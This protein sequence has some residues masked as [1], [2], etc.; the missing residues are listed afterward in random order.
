M[1]FTTT[2]VATILL[3]S[4]STAALPTPHTPHGVVSVDSL[5]DRSFLS[6]IFGSA[7][8]DAAEDGAA[9]ASEA[10]SAADS[11]AEDSA[12][13]S[14]GTSTADDAS[15][16]GGILSHFD[17]VAK[18]AAKKALKDIFGVGTP[19]SSGAGVSGAQTNSTKR[20]FDHFDTY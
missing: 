16:S 5:T 7:A 4:V 8:D 17:N 14:T 6:D 12:E 20:A 18:G 19:S 11:S 10:E 1:H 13:D 15:A 3:L 9:A 2:I